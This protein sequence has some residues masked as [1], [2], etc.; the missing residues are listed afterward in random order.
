MQVYANM[1]SLHEP[2][3]QNII[4]FMD[5]LGLVT[6]MTSKRLKQNT[7]CC[8]YDCDMMVNNVSVSGPDGK[9][10]SVQLTSRGAG[11]MGHSPLVFSHILKSR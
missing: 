2:T 9:V 6:K 5:G 8:G 1:I 10:F 3:V 4:G 7:Y 11:P